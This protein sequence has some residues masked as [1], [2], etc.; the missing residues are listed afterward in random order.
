MRASWLGSVEPNNQW[1]VP[2][3]LLF[4]KNADYE[5]EKCLEI[6]VP[7]CILH[8]KQKKGHPFFNFDPPLW[9][10]EK[11]APFS[12]KKRDI[13]RICLRYKV[14]QFSWVIFISH[15][16]QKSEK[17]KFLKFF[18]LFAF[19]YKVEK[20]RLCNLSLFRLFGWQ[21]SRW[22]LS[23]FSHSLSTMIEHKVCNACKLT[24]GLLR[25]CRHFLTAV[26]REARRLGFPPFFDNCPPK[27]RNKE[28]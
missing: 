23:T 4:T 27:S 26:S 6:K 24:S 12:H 25:I 9:K 17:G 10:P 20:S 18:Q 7:I 11:S 5:N 3:I 1:S 15:Y 28:R 21:L 8:S 2:A 13:F 16:S 19:L 22:Q 14:N